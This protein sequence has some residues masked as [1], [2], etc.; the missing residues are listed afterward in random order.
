MQQVNTIGKELRAIRKMSGESIE[1]AAK[2]LSID[3]THL[4]K[5]ELG[6]YPPSE[7]LLN[8]ILAHFSVE[9]IKANQLRSILRRGE[10]EHV[11][12]EG[13]KRKEGLMEQKIQAND[14]S[15]SVQVSFD[16]N[17]IQVLYSDS[18]MVGSTDYGLTMDIAQTAPGNPQQQFIVARIGMSFDHAK[19][20]LEA[21]NDHL[22]KNER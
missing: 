1:V 7:E 18:I 14:P 9:G 8:K 3:R 10:V 20:L 21:I 2:Q 4:N 13:V 5:I 16:P 15:Q 19:K 11:V 12:V 17:K 22:Q 6:F